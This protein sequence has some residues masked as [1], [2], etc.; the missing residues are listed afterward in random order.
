[1]SKDPALDVFVGNVSVTTTEQ[2]LRE[3]FGVVGTVRGVR[4][5]MDKDTGRP[6]G[7]AF[8]EYASVEFV[9]A[10]VRLLNNSELNGRLLRVSFAS[11]TPGATTTSH[12]EPGTVGFAVGSLPLHEVWDLLETM[13]SLNE[14]QRLRPILESYP[15]LVTAAQE[16]KRRLGVQ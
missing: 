1:M 12:G 4:L 3:T 10:A 5:V 2:Q 7:Y 15:Q 9:S 14:Q 8:V 13:K 6:K 16:L 11:G